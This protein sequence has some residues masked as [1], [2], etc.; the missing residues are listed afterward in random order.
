MKCSLQVV[1]VAV[2]V[3]LLVYRKFPN[4]GHDEEDDQCCHDDTDADQEVD[5]SHRLQQVV[6]VAQALLVVVQFV[7]YIRVVLLVWHW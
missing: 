2:R 7:V 6:E 1:V 5:A 4:H 3:G